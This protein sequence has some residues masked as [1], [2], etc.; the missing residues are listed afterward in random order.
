MTRG[1]QQHERI[2][3]QLRLHGS[4]LADVARDLSV[5]RTSVTAVSQGLHRSRRIEAAIAGKLGVT[6]EQLWPKR[7]APLPERRAS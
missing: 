5:A 7:Y 3:M 1:R 4:S 6:P 2:K